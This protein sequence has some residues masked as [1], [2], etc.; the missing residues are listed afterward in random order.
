MI[1]VEDKD[2]VYITPLFVKKSHHTM[3]VVLAG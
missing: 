3:S 1:M 2:T